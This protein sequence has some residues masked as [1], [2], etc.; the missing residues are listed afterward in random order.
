[1]ATLLIAMAWSA[2]MV[3]MNT[4]PRLTAAEPPFVR[5]RGMYFHLANWG[6]PFKYTDTTAELLPEPR[7]R[8]PPFGI[9]RP[10]A[11]AGDVLV[12]VLLVVVLTWG[13]NQLLRRVGARLRRRKAVEE[14]T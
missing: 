1:L 14:Q 6:W 10:W 13:S 5:P 8:F 2:V 4:T 12:G 11:L 9:T 3:W 7:P